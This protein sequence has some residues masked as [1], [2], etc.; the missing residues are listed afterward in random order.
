MERMIDNEA[1]LQASYERIWEAGE[2]KEEPR[3]YRWILDLLEVEP[4]R[5]LLDV[6]CGAGY[7]LHEAEMRRLRVSGIDISAN[8][9]RRAQARCSRAEIR[10]GSAEVL[11][12]PARQFDYVTCLGS[13]EHFVHPEVALTEMRRVL[14]PDGKMCVVV[15]NQWFVPDVLRGWIDGEG[16]NHGQEI[17][18]FYSLN[19]AKSLLKKNGLFLPKIAAYSPPHLVQARP[20]KQMNGL[21]QLLYRFLYRMIPVKGAY[22]FVFI[23]TPQAVHAPSDLFVDDEEFILNGWHPLEHLERKAFRWTQKEASVAMSVPISS[24]HL[25]IHCFSCRP[26]LEAEP[27]IVRVKINGGQVG[28]IQFS[29]PGWRTESVEIPPQYRNGVVTV[30]LN[31]EKEWVPSQ[32]LESEDSRILGIGVHRITACAS[33]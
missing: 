10:Q 9:I 25:R 31:V 26:N 1:E 19:E 23:C 33:P 5:L 3:Y 21:L 4:G 13:L 22:V 24:T 20:F 14:K 16:L 8:A 29:N 15:P 6:A 27:Q 32:L 28:R 7:L 17:E 12:Y 18:R 30:E 2:L 11:P